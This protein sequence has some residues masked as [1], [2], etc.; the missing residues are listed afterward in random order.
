[1]TRSKEKEIKCSECAICWRIQYNSTIFFTLR[2][3]TDQHMDT[4][5]EITTKHYV[6]TFWQN[7]LQTGRISL[8]RV[9][10]NIITCER[11]ERRIVV[12]HCVS[13]G[14]KGSV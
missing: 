2:V 7:F 1:M 11:R 9:A 10:E 6:L 14:G 12:L 5:K 8:S 4:K 13:T 3:F